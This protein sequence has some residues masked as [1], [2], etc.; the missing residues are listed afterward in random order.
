MN[1]NNVVGEDLQLEIVAAF[2]VVFQ[3]VGKGRGAEYWQ[4]VW[5]YLKAN[6]AHML[7]DATTYYASEGHDIEILN[8]MWAWQDLHFTGDR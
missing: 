2:G 1:V 7:E 5:D 8:E 4:N 6:H 3:V